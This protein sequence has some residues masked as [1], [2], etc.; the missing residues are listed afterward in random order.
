M[1]SLAV[2][3]RQGCPA[4]AA[5]AARDL[6]S[7]RVLLAA[8]TYSVP[9]P[10]P[11]AQHGRSDPTSSVRCASGIDGVRW[12]RHRR[13]TIY[14][15]CRSARFTVLLTRAVTNPAPSSRPGS[16]RTW[17]ASADRPRRRKRR[18]WVQ[19]FAGAD[20]PF[21]VLKIRR[22]DKGREVS[23]PDTSALAGRGPCSSTTSCP[24]HDGQAIAS[25]RRVRITPVCIGVRCALCRRC[26]DAPLAAGPNGC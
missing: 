17:S 22:G 7:P 13:P 3:R 16:R 10:G 5:D 20:A 24:A 26:Y 21:T 12:R 14:T 4:V 19:E 1:A 15:C 18:Q 23:L 25:V 8:P 2:A 6:N 9:A 11:A